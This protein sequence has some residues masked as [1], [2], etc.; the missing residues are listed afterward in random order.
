[1]GFGK[2]LEYREAFFHMAD[3]IASRTGWEADNVSLVEIEEGSVDVFIRR[4]VLV[5]GEAGLLCFPRETGNGMLD[6]GRQAIDFSD[7]DD[8]R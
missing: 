8:A 4:G 2:P 3:K 1:M 7:H 5:A 6:I